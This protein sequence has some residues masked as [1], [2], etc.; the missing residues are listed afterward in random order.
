MDYCD[1]PE[2]QSENPLAKSILAQVAHG[3]PHAFQWMWAFW[4]FE[5]V[6]DDLVDGDK[7]PTIADVSKSLANFVTALSLNPFYLRHSATLFPL[8]LSA[9]NRWIDGD[10]IKSPAVRCGEIDI[11]LHVAYL[12]GGW[13]HMR[14]VSP[15][16]RQYDSDS[17]PKPT[18]TH[19]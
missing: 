8:I 4:N 11:F 1:K 10:E 3:D 5:H 9:C 15:I 19:Q 18:T 12:T 2:E 17:S 16:V 6:I 14:A 13:D 7:S